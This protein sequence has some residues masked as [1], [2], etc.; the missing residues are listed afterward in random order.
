MTPTLDVQGV[1]KR[2]GVKTVLDKVSFVAAKGERP[3]W[4]CQDDPL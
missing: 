4:G 1:K 3:Q 2:Y